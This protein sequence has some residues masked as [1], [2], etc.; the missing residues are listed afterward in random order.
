MPTET[1]TIEELE[2]RLRAHFLALYTM[3]VAI[4]ATNDKHG[5]EI[6]ANLL[7]CADAA[8]ER[9]QKSCSAELRAL[10]TMLSSAA[11]AG[12]SRH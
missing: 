10:A 1:A 12:F 5:H 6:I 4:G 9:V 7:S 3:G 8:D 11:A 2:E